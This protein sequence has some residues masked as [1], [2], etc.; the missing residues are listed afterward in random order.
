M[1]DW[2]VRVVEIEGPI[3]WL[4]AARRIANG[5]GVQR[6]GGRIQ[7]SIERACKVGSRNGRF[8]ADGDYLK[9]ISQ[10]RCSIRD[11]SELPGQMKR[12]S[13]VSPEEIDAA[14]ELVT[15]E[16]YGIGFDDAAAAACRILGFARVTEEMLVIAERRRD[17][18]LARRRLEQRGEMLFVSQSPVEQ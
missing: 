9:S 17:S 2:L 8:L 10:E 4:E 5:A 6:V 1:I 13:L 15:G 11:R 12:L 16:S 7:T 3:H 14:I 18:L